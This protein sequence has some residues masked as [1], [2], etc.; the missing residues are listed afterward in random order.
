M[1][2]YEIGGASEVPVYVTVTD[3]HYIFEDMDE[4]D[5]A[6]RLNKQALV[7]GDSDSKAMAVVG[8]PHELVELVA[9]ISTAVHQA[10]GYTPAQV[11]KLRDLC[12]RF[13]YTFDLGDYRPRFDLP[14]GYVAGWVGDLYVGV[15]PDG[16]ASS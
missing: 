6:V 16:D 14:D 3:L 12:K 11:A 9:R 4:A 8:T 13:E 15:S 1:N 10:I 7:I 2:D 5:E